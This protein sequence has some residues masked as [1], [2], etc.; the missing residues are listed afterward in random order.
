MG[1]INSLIRQCSIQVIENGLVACFVE[2]HMIDTNNH[3][4]NNILKDI[5]HSDVKKIQ[6]WLDANKIILNLNNLERIFE[7]LIAK[8]DRKLNGAFYTPKFVIDYIIKKT[9][10]KN[11]RNV[12]DCSCGS[13]SFLV[14]ATKRLSE[15]MH[16]PISDVIENCVYG[17]D[18]LEI[19]I[20]RAKIM[21]T[22]LMLVNGDERKDVSFNLR[23]ANSLNLDWN[24][25]FPEIKKSGGFDAMVGNPPYVRAR[26][27]PDEVKISLHTSRWET[28]PTGKPDLF[29][30]FVE[31][32]VNLINEK[33]ILGYIIPNTI[34]TS[35]ASKNLRKMLQNKELLKEIIDFDHLQ[36]FN[37]ATIYTCIAIID[38]KHKSHFRY[39]LVEDPKKLQKINT[40]KPQDFIKI[41]FNNLN[42]L[43]W[44]LLNDIDMKNVTKIESSGKPLKSICRIKTGI[45]TL[46]NYLYVIDGDH[47]NG[48]YYEK[49]YNG[50]TYKIE[51]EITCEVLK[52]GQVKNE[53]YIKNNKMQI[54]YPYYY[55]KN[56]T[57]TII[58][59]NILKKKYPLCYEYLVAI[60]S[61]LKKRDNGKKT[62]ATWYAYGRTQGLVDYGPKLIMPD[63]SY[64]PRFVLCN[65]KYLL[66]FT[67]YGL[68]INPGT[69]MNLKVLCKI[70]NSKVFSYY[71]DKTSR[72]YQNGYRSYAK[73]FVEDFTIPQ[74]TDE[75]IKIMEL[76]NQIDE[77]LISKYQLYI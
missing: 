35:L 38:K 19:N 51:K 72:R 1:A 60:R 75:E 64:K 33:G 6:Q 74:F 39:I 12:C 9:I 15:V 27:L 41:Y 44:I 63:M 70:L 49:T 68:W 77:M 37:D 43:K 65:K 59:E 5:K 36:V 22:L 55:D 4:I 17:V 18:V 73:H 71:M 8:K 11:T 53:Q 46:R 10:T 40:I 26:N 21:L 28:A 7:L 76:T 67:G 23:T 54:I 69:N 45:S 31:L 34:Q 52:S 48:G 42:Y 24:A 29:I 14:E 3:L 32:G 50:K 57:V 47:V 30:P 58:A 16:K 62:Y 56:K 20:R 2:K 66:F 25:E 61:E 13:G